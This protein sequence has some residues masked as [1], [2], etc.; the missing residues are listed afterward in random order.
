MFGQVM[1]INREGKISDF[2]FKQGR[3]FGRQAAHIFLGVL[4]G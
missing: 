2:G 1:I 3:S 4:L